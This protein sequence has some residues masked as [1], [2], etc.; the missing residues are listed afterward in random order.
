MSSYKFFKVAGAIAFPNPQWYDRGMEAKI[1]FN[2][3]ISFEEAGEFDTAYYLKLS[4][5]E[6]LETI[7][8]L[9]E[10]HFN[11]TG[12]LP[13]ENGKRLRRVFRVIKQA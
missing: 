6:R 1:W 2:K 9:R 10:A 4:S 8:I 12:L 13:H 3:S 11:A 7:Q 5:V